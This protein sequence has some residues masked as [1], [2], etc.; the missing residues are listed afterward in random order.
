HADTCDGAGA[1]QPNLAA[2]AT[3]CGNTTDSTCDRADT[4]DGAGTCQSN[5]APLGAPCGDRTDLSRNDAPCDGSGTCQPHHQPHGTT[6]PAD[7]NACTADVCTNGVCTHTP[8]TSP[9]CQVPTEIC[10]NCIDDDGD[11][12]TDFEDPDCCAGA[13]Q[14]ALTIKKARLAPHGSTT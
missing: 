1:C 12:L 7:G 10:G 3:P 2:A 9:E 4:C 14:A 11:G 8:S 13:T 5:I 6:H